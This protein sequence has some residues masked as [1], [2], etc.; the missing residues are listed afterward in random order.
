MA[1]DPDEPEYSLSADILAPEGYGEIVG[2]GERLADHELLLKRIHEH[3]LPEEAF[4]W[5]LDLR[6]FGTLP[7]RG[8]RDGH[9]ARGD[10]DLRHRPPA[11]DDRVPAHAVPDLPVAIRAGGL[12]FRARVRARDADGRGAAGRSRAGVRRCRSRVCTSAPGVPVRGSRGPAARRCA[13]VECDVGLVQKDALA[14]DEAG[15]VDGAGGAF[16]AGWDG[17]RGAGGRAGCASPARGSCSATSRRSRSPPRPRPGCLR[18]R[19]ATSRGTGS[20]RHLAARQP[21]LAEAAAQAARGLRAGRAAAA[22]AV[23]RRPVGLPADR[24]RAARGPQAPVRRRPRRAGGSG[25]TRGPSCCF[26][27]RR[28]DAGARARGA[29]AGSTSTSSC[30]RGR[31]A[32]GRAPNLRRARRPATRRPRASTTRTSSAPPTSS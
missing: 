28:R 6:R 13:R 19:S 9:R 15:T 14:I 17:A 31:R 20:T 11:R 7:A 16:L 30:S 10:L 4:R 18:S 3:G 32:A 22:A 5:Y 26:V 8:L 2:G 24:G 12:R 29:L 23:R 25:S 1:P 27:R 21:A